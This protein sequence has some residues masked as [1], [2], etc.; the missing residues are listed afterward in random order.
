VS[1]AT[2]IDAV[3]EAT[4]VPSFSTIGPRLRARLFEWSALPRLEGRVV[5]VTGAT[6]GL[7]EAA[8]VQLA[9]L[10]AAVCVLGR[11]AQRV[12]AAV[13]RVRVASSSY[14]VHGEVADL[15]D[16]SQVRAFATRFVAAHARLDAIVHNAGALSSE[17]AETVDGIEVTVQTHLVAPFLLTT[18]LQ[19]MLEASAPARVVWVT[20]GGMYTQRLSV[21]DLELAPDAF[22]GVTAYARAKRAQVA[23]VGHW[24][25]MLQRRGVFAHAMH[26]GWADTP[27]VATSLPRFHRVLG[28]ILRSPAEGADTMA[29]LVASADAVATSGALWLDRRQ[30][31]AHKVPWTRRRDEDAEA[32]RLLAWCEA[33]AG[34]SSPPTGGRTR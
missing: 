21:D 27:G 26:P 19:P 13:D 12:A 20:S 31:P 33:R 16:L 5:L 18:L 7:G 17:H 8:A 2:T 24:A 9:R 25:P 32:A 11:D 6:S 29:W 28:P 10:G 22:D 23:L 4:V 15:A 30:R 14:A 34:A 1:V 3:M